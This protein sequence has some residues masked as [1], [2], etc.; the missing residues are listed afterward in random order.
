V[1]GNSYG[2][3]TWNKTFGG[4][5]IYFFHSVQ[6]TNDGGYI[7][8]GATEIYGTGQGDAWLI[9]TDA[10]G[11]KL[12]D[13]T[14]GGIRDECA[15]AVQQTS[16]GG[17]IMAGGTVSFGVGDYDAWLIKTDADGNEVW[18]KTFGGS[19]WD[20]VWAMQQTSEGG[21]ILAGC[22][23]SFGVFNSGAWLIKTAA[24]GNAPPTP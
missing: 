9:K 20:L 18:D 3:A 23:D 14:F 10:D 12:W 11:N 5:D 16:D 7:L 19:G 4:S 8:T 6:Q 22:T 1:R 13:K 17:Y 2:I 24:D 21:Y 15:H